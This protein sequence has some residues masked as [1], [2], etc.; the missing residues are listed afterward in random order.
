L[1]ALDNQS[2][3]GWF[4]DGDN[5]KNQGG[6]FHDDGL[7]DDTTQ[8]SKDYVGLWNWDGFYSILSSAIFALYL[9]NS[10]PILIE[11]LH[12]KYHIFGT[13]IHYCFLATFFLYLVISIVSVGYFASH[14]DSSI[15]LNF[16]SFNTLFSKSDPSYDWIDYAIKYFIIVFPAVD[17][18]SLYPLSIIVGM[19]FRKF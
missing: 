15:N 6:V 2:W 10:I 12:E 19:L 5:S 13:I 18:V 8:V 4:G 16:T 17:V 3:N 1:V 9:N 7:D 14:V 11:S